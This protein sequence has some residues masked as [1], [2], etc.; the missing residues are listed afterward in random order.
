MKAI[1]PL[2][3]TD[4]VLTSSD[5]TEPETGYP[6]FSAATTYAIAATVSVNSPS[7]VVTITIASPGVVSWVAHGLREG[8]RLKF[9][10]TGS[11]PT[12]LSTGVE[13]YVIPLTTNGNDSFR[14]ST[15]RNGP[16]I[17]TTGAQSGVHT[18]VV[19]SHRAYEALAPVT[20]TVVTMTIAAPCV[21]T[22][23]AHGM[24][25]NTPI[26]FTT[27]GALPTGLIPDRIYYVLAP[28]AGSFNVSATAGG[29]AIT[30]TGTQSGVHTSTRPAPRLDSTAWLELGAT[31]RWKMFD[32]SLTSQT[33]NPDAITNVFA[34]I[35][36]AD[37]VACL[38]IDAS[39]LHIVQ[40]DP[41]DGIVFDHTYNLVS[42]EGIV[43]FYEYCFEPVIRLSDKVVTGLPPYAGSSLAVTLANS[44]GTV[45]CGAMVLGQS[46]EIGDAERG[47]S[48]GIQDYSVKRQDDFGN[49]DILERAWSRTGNFTVYVDDGLVDAVFNLLATYRATAI[50]YVGDDGEHTCMINYGFYK[51]FSLELAYDEFS[52]YTL[53]TASLA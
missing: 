37:S 45:A 36:R 47:S 27:T 46:R 53:E 31:N 16:P 25:A 17:K 21:V 19:S 52:I 49:W 22:W 42:T 50:V 32:G 18:A 15:S 38:N 10:T 39:T 6:E 12:G 5:V 2:D 43:D 9:T 14:L 48:V 4:V 7:K 44:G 23:A 33:I 8:Q 13:Y 28:L 11:L 30:T 51:N 26:I 1:R 41:I 3:I 34:V 29:A 35:G 40:T 20:P 24:A